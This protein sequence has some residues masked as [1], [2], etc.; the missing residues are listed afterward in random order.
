[1]YKA[2]YGPLVLGYEAEAPLGFM[3]EVEI[4]PAA[5]GRSC[6]VRGAKEC[7]PVA[8][9]KSSKNSFTRDGMTFEVVEGTEH[10]FTPLYHLLDPAVSIGANYHRMV[11]VNMYPFVE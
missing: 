5:D 10:R 4:V 9:G 8:A 3:G 2:M 6:A 1:R 7:R 11:T